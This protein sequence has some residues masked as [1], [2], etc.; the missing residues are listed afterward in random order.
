MT[1]DSVPPTKNNT[2]ALLGMIG[3]I[4]ADVAL[5]ASCCILPVVG[6]IFAII[7]GIAALIFGFIGRKQI[8]ESDGEE[9]GDG[10]ALAALITGGIGVGLGLV[11]LVFYL[12]VG[13]ASFVPFF[14]DL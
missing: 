10:M 12:I 7:F 1:I 6:H 13:I 5:L 4:I 14:S 2:M 3:G 11:G 9:G 8:K